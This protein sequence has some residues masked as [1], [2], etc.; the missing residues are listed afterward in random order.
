MVSFRVGSVDVLLVNFVKIDPEA[1][2]GFYEFEAAGLAWLAVDGGV[3]VAPVV[4]VSPGRIAVPQFELVE[5]SEDAA[6]EFG[7]RLARTHGAGAEWFGVPPQGWVED[8]FVGHL[9]LP[10]AVFDPAMTFGEFFAEYR[11]EPFLRMA[12]DEELLTSH[13]VAEVADFMD[14]VVTGPLFSSSITPARLHGDLWSG[15]FV[16]SKDN[17]VVLVDPAAH[18][19]FGESDLAM[20]Q[21]FGCP[22]LDEILLGYEE[23]GPLPSGWELRFLALQVHPL[24]VHTLFFGREYGSHVMAAVR[25]FL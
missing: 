24:L 17:G 20:M 4:E 16:W 5:P 23:T 9:A 1:P 18:G 7:A 21:L 3:P 6:F 11:V 2:P 19:G 8:G 13:E 25:K 22:M 14:V 10:M 15:N 12:A